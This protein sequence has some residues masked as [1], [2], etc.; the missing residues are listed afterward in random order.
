MKL[1]LKQK[2]RTKERIC[3]VSQGERTLQISQG[4]V[5]PALTKI[6]PLT[7]LLEMAHFNPIFKEQTQHTQNKLEFIHNSPP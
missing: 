7:K 6:S 5:T 2:I 3:R 4:T 1:K